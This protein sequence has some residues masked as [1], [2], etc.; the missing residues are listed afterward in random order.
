MYFS[1][2][3]AMAAAS[4]AVCASQTSLLLFFLREDRDNLMDGGSEPHK[5]EPFVGA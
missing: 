4:Y 1:T 2:A 5:D 3:S